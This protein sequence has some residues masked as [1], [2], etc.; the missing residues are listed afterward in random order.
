[1]GVF[2]ICRFINIFG[3]LPIESRISAFR[4]MFLQHG[5][6][7][8][9]KDHKCMLQ[10]KHLRAVFIRLAARLNLVTESLSKNI[11]NGF[12]GLALKGT[13]SS[14]HL[15]FISSPCLSMS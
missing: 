9:N 13:F 2:A 7:A 6:D 14:S 11:E 1:M 8:T 5:S 4:G 12:Y 10:L 3:L 15:R